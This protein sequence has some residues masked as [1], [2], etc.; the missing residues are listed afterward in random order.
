MDL[1]SAA[2][3]PTM[4]SQHINLPHRST[5]A[6]EMQPSR[7]RAPM[8]IPNSRGEPPPPPL[9]PPTRMD[10]I[11]AGSDPGWE[12]EHRRRALAGET[13]GSIGSEASMPQ[14]WIKQERDDGFE[15]PA[16]P[17]RRSSQ[18]TIKPALEVHPKYEFP[19]HPDE[20]Y[21]S[22]PGA[23]PASHQ[24]VSPLSSPTTAGAVLRGR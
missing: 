1:T 2:S 12:W 14:G 3:P 17:R 20:G 18:A 19:R 22:L 21:Y 9:P 23:S 4:S 16:Y 8:T 24:S 15:R 5:K 10:E 13:R 7:T 6:L 11:T